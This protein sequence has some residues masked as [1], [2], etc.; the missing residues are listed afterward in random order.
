[1]FDLVQTAIRSGYATSVKKPS[2]SA[3]LIHAE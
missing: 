2:T 1:M 3:E